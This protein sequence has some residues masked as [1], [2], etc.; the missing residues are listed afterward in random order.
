MNSLFEAIMAGGGHEENQAE[1]KIKMDLDAALETLTEFKDNYANRVGRFK[2][3]DVITPRKGTAYRS[4][5]NPHMICEVMDPPLRFMGPDPSSH[6]FGMDYDLRVL[7]IYDDI[8]TCFTVE[9]W[10]FV[11]WSKELMPNVL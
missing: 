6:K 1:P 2:V 10:A 8:V 4:S 11:P 3:G 9:S 5:G 7:T